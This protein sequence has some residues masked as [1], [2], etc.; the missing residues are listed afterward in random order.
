MKSNF[1]HTSPITL[2]AAL[3]LRG[4]RVAKAVEPEDPSIE[5]IELQLAGKY[6]GISVN[7]GPFGYCITRGYIGEVPVNLK[8]A[9]SFVPSPPTE[10]ELFYF[11]DGKG[12]L[13][14]EI[15]EIFLRD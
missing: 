7:V 5:D 3:N 13:A 6:D 11:V 9:Y 2:I 15:E 14:A 12:N 1:T 4:I 10:R 8:A